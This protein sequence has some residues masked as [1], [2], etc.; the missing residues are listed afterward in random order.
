MLQ[1]VVLFLD[2]GRENKNQPFVISGGGLCPAIT[3]EKIFLNA[4]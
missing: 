2:F 3:F 4:F 1:A